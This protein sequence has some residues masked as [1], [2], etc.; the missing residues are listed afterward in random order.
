M[1]SAVVL[2]TQTY[3]IMNVYFFSYHNRS[4]FITVQLFLFFWHL[5]LICESLINIYK[6][7]C[8]LQV[9]RDL[10]SSVEDLIQ[11]NKGYSTKINRVH[12]D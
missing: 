1:W 10:Q 11:H 6:N 3:K 8:A 9:N 4:V 5:I 7:Q 2:F 12:I